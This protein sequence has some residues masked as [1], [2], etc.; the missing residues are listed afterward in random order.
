[1]ANAVLE[2]FGV[3]CAEWQ[4]RL[5][6]SRPDR[7]AA[8]WSTIWALCGRRP[9]S[10]PGGRSIRS[11]PAV[12]ERV[13]RAG[14]M[15]REWRTVTAHLLTGFLGSGKTS[16]LKRLLAQPDLPARPC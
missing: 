2:P 11:D 16:L 6:V 15:I 5:T 4:G 7:A 1:M 12:I 10:W 13:E 9:R 8:W 14:R 3:R